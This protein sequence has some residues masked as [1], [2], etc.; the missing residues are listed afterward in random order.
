MNILYTT[1][2]TVPLEE[3]QKVNDFYVTYTLLQFKKQKNYFG[4]F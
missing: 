2:L 1:E 3:V 4:D